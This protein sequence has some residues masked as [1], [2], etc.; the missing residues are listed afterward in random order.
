MDLKVFAIEHMHDFF[1]IELILFLT[2]YVFVLGVSSWRVLE[3]QF[4]QLLF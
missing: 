3:A 1:D 4:L 2:A